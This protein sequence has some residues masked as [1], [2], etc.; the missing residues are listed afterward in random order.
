[1]KKKNHVQSSSVPPLNMLEDIAKGGLLRVP[2]SYSSQ[3]Q[4]DMDFTP[5]LQAPYNLSL[6]IY[7]VRTA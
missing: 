7:R 1:M 2:S 6:T 3:H 4:R 5:A